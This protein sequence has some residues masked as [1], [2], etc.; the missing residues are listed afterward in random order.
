LELL[1]TDAL[2]SGH[3]E[4]QVLSGTGLDESETLVR[5]SLDGAFSHDESLESAAFRSGRDALADSC[6]S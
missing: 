6:R 1:E 5:Q 4:E 3:V 2:D